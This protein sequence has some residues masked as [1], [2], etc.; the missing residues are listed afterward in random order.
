[1]VETSAA[2]HWHPDLQYARPAPA[3]RSRSPLSRILLSLYRLRALRRICRRAALRLEGGAFHS[4]TLRAILREHHDV[5][6]GPYSYG[7]VLSPGV[8]PPGT[9]V[10][11]YC[12][13]AGGLVVRRRDHPLK[14]PFLHPFFYN[15]DLGFVAKDTIE[16]DRDNPLTI[17]NDVWIGD[18]VT[19]LSGCR[20]IGNGAA[21]GAGAVV[22]RDVAPYSVVAGVPARC[23]RMRFDQDAID[24]L[25]RSRWWEHDIATLIG[26]L[27]ADGPPGNPA[28]L[29]FS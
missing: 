20:H 17:G 13:V 15:A 22:T 6:V 5:T 23:I 19:V 9:T 26:L 7:P 28:E 16:R 29:P 1:M 14:H 8:L 18:R 11:A 2:G 25:E 24:R 4:T 3:R 27:P 10:G 21:I 12:S